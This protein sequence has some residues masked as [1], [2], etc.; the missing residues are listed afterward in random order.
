MRE[1]GLTAC[2][3]YLDFFPTSTQRTAV[4]TAANCCR[5]L[6]TDSFP[7]VR[8]VMP[9][10]LNVLSSND[11]KVV[12]QGCLCVSRIV[13]SFKHN[14]EKLEELIEP[15]MLKAV[16]RLLLPGTTNLIGPHIHTQFLRVLSITC[17][18][19]PRLSAELLKMDVVDTLYQILTGIS[20]PQLDKSSVKMDGVLVMQALIHR[21]R[22]QV[23]E[24]LNVIC[25]LLPGVPARN[26]N[27]EDATLSRFF[28][29][30]MTLGSQS[31]NAKECAEKRRSTLTDC[32]VQLK[33]FTM[34]LLPT[35]TDAF[36]STVNLGVRQ[37]VLVAQ[38][39]MLHNL[40]PA[41]IEEALRTVPYASFLGAILSQKDHP[42]LV[43][44]ALRCAELL[45]QR[46]EHVYQCQFHREGVISEIVKQAEE[47]LST[48]KQINHP[49]GLPSAS[50]V[51]DAPSQRSASRDD[52]PD[53]N[54]GSDSDGHGGADDE[55]DD[56][57]QDDFPDDDMSGS[58]SMAFDTKLTT[59]M[60]SILKDLVTRDAR[61][62]L[63]VYE[64]SEGRGMRDKAM[65][66]LHQLQAL[67]ADIENCYNR[68]QDG[69]P[70]F[71][72]LASYFDGDALESITSSEILNSGIIKVLLNV[73]GGFQ[74]R[75]LVPCCLWTYPVQ[76][77]SM[78]ISYHIAPSMREARGAFLQGFMGS[79]ISEKAQSQSTATTPFSVLINK[80]QD[81]LSRTEHFEVI[82]VGQNSLENTRSNATHMLGK[83]LRLKLVADDDSDIPRSYRNIMVSIHAIA[84]FKSLDDFLH[85]RISLSDQ[86]RTSRTREAVLSQIANAARLRE[87]LAGNSGPTSG[88][89]ADEALRSAADVM[90]PPPPARSNESSRSAKTPPIDDHQRTKHKR[91][92]RHQQTQGQNENG[93]EP[94]E[95]ADAKQLSDNDENDGA[96][97]D[98][99]DANALNAIVDD[100]DEDAGGNDNASEENTPDPT[101]VNM[102]VA[103][104]GKVTARKEDGTR[105]STPSQS[106][107]V[108]KSSSS[109]KPR[110]AAQAAGNSSLASAGRPHSYAA[111]MASVP[112]DWH[113]EFSID[114]KPIPNDT[115]IYRAVHHDRENID[116]QGT[117]NVWSAIHTIKFKRVPGPPSP[118]P[119]TAAPGL[120]E[121]SLTGGRDGMPPSLSKDATTSSILRLLG[122]LHEMNATL[123]DILAEIKEL[124]AVKP[125]PLAQFINTK[126]TAKLNRQL[127]EPL[128]VASSC[129]PRWSE[130]LARLFPFLFPFETRHLFLQSTAFG[131]SRAMM[132]WHN[133]QNRDDRDRPDDRP[134]LGRLPRQKVRISR[135][136]ILDSAMKVME[137]YGSSPSILEVEYFEEVG[138]GLGPTL[139][140]YSNVSKEFSRKKL[141]LWRENDNHN[142]DEYAF[143]R[144]GLFPA[145]M[146]EEQ[147]SNESGK[148]QLHLFRILGK[149]VAR[150]MLDS[151]IIDVSFNP[152]FFRIADGSSSVSPSLGTVKAVDHD[153][154]N[155]LILLKRFANAKKAVEN[156]VSLATAEK[157]QA[158]QNVEV[159]GA[160]VE[161]LGL[162]FTLPGYPNIDL[163]KDGSD[164]AVTIENVD[165]YVDQ[166][167]D[168][169]LGSG[170][171][172]QVE[173][174]RTG[175]S[176]VFPYSSLRTF[177]PSELVILFGKAEEDWCIESEY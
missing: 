110:P 78:L 171:R 106:T 37:K 125:E 42:S 128:I 103:S 49:R 20:P 156:D 61:A 172:R 130:D 50:T 77:N 173:A 3:T 75:F 95:C 59:R 79:T 154:A 93:N 161:D 16:L 99:G 18:S 44:L 71:K 12:E 111:A 141:R 89:G 153:L 122:V 168:M 104:T 129:L 81:L 132:R 100:L 27:Q 123:D 26:Y 166:V 162:D 145:P 135:S 96:E 46:L 68:N 94:L 33:R 15:A 151:R 7:V 91:P 34:I 48:D 6:P 39:K 137:L 65:E 56:D 148:K 9:T 45:F 133:T 24:T 90:N 176:Q 102:E 28:E 97:G 76:L 55:D 101:A 2:L 147:A 82:T 144:A 21:P 36:S 22:E 1:G 54:P 165:L 175:F 127:E 51:E 152:A 13:E 73:F 41:V 169:T 174:F 170:V 124:V 58:E 164:T 23:F 40:E 72:K 19:S 118:E 150:S 57:D 112:Q 159:D 69:L 109:S 142:S 92:G 38:L 32:K 31:P 116:V 120:A 25:E 66:I 70:L 136:R 35:L 80:L 29:S 113:I 5:N 62:F 98:G 143:G 4:T 167:V 140:F 157:A 134:F 64:A 163:I 8:D 10:L 119:S 115:T 63:E 107:P 160:K 158:L 131:Y 105:V 86:P 146:S 108:S 60:D 121:S 43:S 149:F 139:E 30:N 87:Q 53:D 138:T 67:A 47:P 11:P 177:T 85:P 84:T 126:L 155:S 17:K 114:G 14:P 52:S 88:G 74:C 117:R 83:Q